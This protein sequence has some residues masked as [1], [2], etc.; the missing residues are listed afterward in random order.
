M[1]SLNRVTL[2]GHLAAD[3]DFRQT[4]TGKT[5]AT[6]PVAT[7]RMTKDKDGE[8]REVA[9]F[10]RIVAWGKLGEICDKYLAK[11]VAVYLEGKLINRSF[12][13]KSGEKHYRAEIV[14]ENL[15]ILTWKKTKDG[16]QELGIEP[17][18]EEKEEEE[19]VVA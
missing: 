6:F 19:A 4:K 11:G 15:N 2:M 9:D 8:K 7:N 10:H 14:A 17:I 16:D 12:E 13:S 3:V 5:L 18:S 1:R